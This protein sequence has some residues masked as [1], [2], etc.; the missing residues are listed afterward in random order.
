MMANPRAAVLL[1]TLF[2][3]ACARSD[4]GKS[5]APV[6]KYSIHGQIMRLNNDDKTATI[7]HKDIVGYMKSM[8]MTFPVR[9]PQEFNALQVGNCVEGSLYVQGDS[10]WLADLKHLEV[11]PDQCVPPVTG[12]P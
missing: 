8:T 7:H 9:D 5:A 6:E 12:Q 2:L 3:A 10:E 11:P 1:L 4:A